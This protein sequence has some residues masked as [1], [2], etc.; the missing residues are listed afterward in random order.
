MRNSWRPTWGE[1][2]YIRLK[3]YPNGDAPCGVDLNPSAGN[4]CKGG[5]ATVKVC[6]QNAI[7]Y[8]NVYPTVV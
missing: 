7:L 3:R 1:S 8:D 4:G 5:P 6:G 2:G